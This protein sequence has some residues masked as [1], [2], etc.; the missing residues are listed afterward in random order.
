MADLESAGLEFAALALR[1]RYADDTGLKDELNRTVT[2]ATRPVLAEIRA[3]L[4]P[5]LP[6]RYAAVLDEDLKLSVSRRTAGSEAG[7]RIEGRPRLKKRKVR[8]VDEGRLTHPLFGDR[9]H[10]YTQEAP[11]VLPGFFTGPC[12]RSGPAMRDAILAAMADVAQ[13]ITK[14]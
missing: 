14:G 5:L 9:E 13:K 10:W 11:S 12:R 1:L 3:D 2:D 6:D 8:N 4:K 7:V